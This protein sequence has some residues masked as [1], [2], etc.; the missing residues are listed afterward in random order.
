[1]HKIGFIGAGNMGGAMAISAAKTLGGDDIIL[2]DHNPAKLDALKD[3][4]GC[5]TTGYSAAAAKDAEFI[6]LAVKPNVIKDAVSEIAPVLAEDQAA[7]IR[8]VL[9][10]IAAGVPTSTIKECAGSDIPV[11]RLLPNTP[12]AVGAGMTLMTA[13][14]ENSPELKEFC[15]IMADAGE[16]MYVPEEKMDTFSTVSGCGPA[17]VYMFIESLADGA[18]K[19]GV[20]RS[21]ATYLAAQTVLGSAKMVLETGEHPDKLKDNVCSPGGSTIEGVTALERGAFRHTVAEAVVQSTEKNK[22]LGK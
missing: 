7:G 10:S 6:V 22:K 8:H 14:D 19:A 16:F 9:V 21:T 15:E 2:A 17:F 12:V 5:S 3:K 20:P 11:I 4:I 1:M 13:D 18:V